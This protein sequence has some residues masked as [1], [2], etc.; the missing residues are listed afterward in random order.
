VTLQNVSPREQYHPRRVK[1]TYLETKKLSKKYI[2][3]KKLMKKE[4]EKNTFFFTFSRIVDLHY[5]CW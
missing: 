3:K 1:K 4:I 5:P 2:L